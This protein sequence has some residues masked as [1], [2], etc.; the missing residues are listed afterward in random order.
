MVANQKTF[1]MIKK[2][3]QFNG[4]DE[5][6][7]PKVGRVAGSK[8]E[9]VEIQAGERSVIRDAIGISDDMD[10]DEMKDMGRSVEVYVVAQ[11]VVRTVRQMDNPPADAV[12]VTN[13]DGDVIGYQCEPYKVLVASYVATNIAD[14]IANEP[15]ADDLKAFVADMELRTSDKTAN[16]AAKMES[17]QAAIATARQTALAKQAADNAARR[18]SLRARRVAAPVVAPVVAPVAASGV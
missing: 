6:R 18:E 9:I 4:G 7:F 15:N 10:I 11:E 13:A 2:L 14:A 17:N 5:S 8:A 1:L 16:L 12:P 3:N